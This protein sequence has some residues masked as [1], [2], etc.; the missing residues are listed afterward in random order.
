MKPEVV[1]RF[2]GSSAG[3][4]GDWFNGSANLSSSF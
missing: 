4:N 2:T 3:T 1:E